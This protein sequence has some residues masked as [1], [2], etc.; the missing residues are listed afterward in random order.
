MWIII[1]IYFVLIIFIVADKTT[2]KTIIRLRTMVFFCLT[3][4]THITT[5]RHC[6]FLAMNAT[7]NSYVTAVSY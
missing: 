4:Y 5:Q 3:L 6:S 2:E 1:F 7:T